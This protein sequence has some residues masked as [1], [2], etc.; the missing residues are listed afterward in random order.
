LHLLGVL[1]PITHY[2]TEIKYDGY[3]DYV[4]A[5]CIEPA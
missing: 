4:M 1:T 3:H 5:D 2:Y